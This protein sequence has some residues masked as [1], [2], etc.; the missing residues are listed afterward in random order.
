[1]VLLIVLWV[2]WCALHS[3][4]ITSPV[5]R[6]CERRGGWMRGG[7]R[8]AYTAVSLVTLVPVVW[9]GQTLP[10]TPLFD[11]PLW[12]RLVQGLLLVIAL[13]LFIGGARAH[14]LGGFLGL[15]QWRDHR[16]GR[17]PEAPLLHTGG[18]LA[19]VRHPGYGGG[20]ALLW[21]LP[22]LTGASLVTRLIL[23][24]YLVI[25]ARLEERKLIGLHGEAY[26]AYRRRVPMFFPWRFGR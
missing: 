3:L 17:E 16:A 13:V 1:M 2:G 6:W 21:G 4:L 5:R 9:Y 23:S 7:Y 22:E 24:A 12:F 15:R 14:D 11:P 26:R 8:L 25:G 19:R 18:I 20:L 10:Q